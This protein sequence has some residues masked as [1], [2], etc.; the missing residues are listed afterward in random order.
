M[1]VCTTRANMY[2]QPYVK[3]HAYGRHHNPGGPGPGFRLVQCTLNCIV[4]PVRGRHATRPGAHVAT[5]RLFAGG[6]W[7][8]SP[9]ALRGDAAALRRYRC[10]YL[11]CPSLPSRRGSAHTDS[12]PIHGRGARS[13][14]AAG[15][16]VL[17]TRVEDVRH[18]LGTFL[19]DGVDATTICRGCSGSLSPEC[20]RPRGAREGPYINAFSRSVAPPGART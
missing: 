7:V 14:R 17:R 4:Y 3:V 18:T 1:Y 5:D 12:R 16:G 11:V 10:R 20:F 8:V 9:S 6:V 2:L 13:A 15:G 19:A